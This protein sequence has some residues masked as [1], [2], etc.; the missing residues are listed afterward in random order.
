MN[1]P[2]ELLRT[3]LNLAKFHREHEKFYS[4]WPLERALALRG[5]SK[6]LT[7]LADRWAGVDPRSDTPHNPYAGCEDLNEVAA[8]Q[9]NGVLFMEGQ[10]E[11]AEIARLARD[12]H[13]MADDFA[14][15]GQWLA[16][17]MNAAWEAAGALVPLPGL[18]DVLG[19]RHRIIANDWQA[20]SMNDLMAR[21]TDRAVSIVESIDWS[22]AALRA[23]L[24]RD[25][26]GP[27]RMHA[28]AELLDRAATLATESAALVR[29]ND[30][31]WR[32]F[33]D[34]VGRV[35]AGD[36]AEAPRSP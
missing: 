2:N 25:R 34:A 22:P 12:L 6:T 31:R 9:S 35:L 36:R 10:G 1:A 17:A 21:L 5:A 13:A 27:P 18:A 23:D 32:V 28:A 19:E 20:A 8:I 26:S 24:A 29:E 4:D 11:P 3:V 16:A 30:R 7:L 33:R 14:Q 15:T